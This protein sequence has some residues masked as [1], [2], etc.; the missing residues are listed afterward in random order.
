MLPWQLTEIKEVVKLLKLK[1][2][3]KKKTYIF[4]NN[5]NYLFNFITYLIT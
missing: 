3:I 1:R 4:I 2:N 5:L